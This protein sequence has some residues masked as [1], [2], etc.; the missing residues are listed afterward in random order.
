[1]GEKVIRM[2]QRELNK[3]LQTKLRE[4]TDANAGLRQMID[5]LQQT[6]DDMRQTIADLQQANDGMRQTID[7]LQQTIDSLNQTIKELTERLAMNSK[8]SSKPPSS[9]GLNKPSPKSLRVPSG[10]KSGGQPGHPGSHLDIEAQP[11]EIIAHAPLACSG[12][13]NYDICLGKAC[14]GE[15]RTVVDAVVAVNVAAHQSLVFDCPLH[16]GQ[17]KGEFPDDVKA[18]V[19]YGENL[20]ALVVAMNTIGAV[21]LS[22]TQEILSGVFGIPLSTGTVVNMVARCA[23]SL[24][25][26]V[27]LIRQKV[28]AS[29]IGHFDETGTRVDGKNHW[30]HN[31]STSEYTHLTINEKRGK[32]GMDAGGVL[33]GFTGI[34]IHDCWSPYWK[35]PFDYRG[36]CNSHLLRELE[37]AEERQPDQK[38]AAEF[39]NLLLDM[40]AAKEEAIKEGKENLSEEQLQ[41][42]DRRYD[43]IIKLA[44]AE[45][46]PPDDTDIGKKRGRKKKG[47]TLSL[48]ERLYKNKASVCL[49]AYDFDVPFDN[50][51]AERDCRMVKTKT[52]VSGCFRSLAGAKD[53]LKIMSFVGSAKKH[54]I[55]G[56]EAIRQAI[57]GN[58]E[59]FMA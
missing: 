44:Y 5:S 8:N 17:R 51:Q 27:E 33:P 24:T 29:A 26:A 1:M 53:Y 41:G 15:T 56:Y 18:P 30:V 19:Q 32:I 42:F 23:D 7:G 13:P 20:Q 39:A 48:I 11:D 3:V 21:S 40:K 25:V 6:I 37:S 57:S 46:P 36:L 55:S 2:S 4:Q 47:K 14:V 35:Y 58:P 54:G 12:C 49:F 9:D 45:N 16:G 52:K 34:P 50:N 28:M 31:A 59:F 43:E 38:W 10:K 22:R